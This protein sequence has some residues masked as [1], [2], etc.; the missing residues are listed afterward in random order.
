MPFPKYIQGSSEGC[1]G[2]FCFQSGKFWNIQKSQGI[3]LFIA[4]HKILMKYLFCLRLAEPFQ[5][6]FNYSLSWEYIS[7]YAI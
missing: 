7:Q 2:Q 5:D 6:V 1:H 3:L 4:E